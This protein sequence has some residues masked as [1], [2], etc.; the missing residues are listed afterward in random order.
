MHMTGTG[1]VQMD[2]ARGIARSGEMSTTMDGTI[3]RQVPPSSGDTAQGTPP[4]A[5]GPGD[6]RIQ[7][8]TKM[9]V[10]AEPQ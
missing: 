1:Q 6:V 9:K 4:P 3:T 10:S 2:L 5:G 8:S 7:G